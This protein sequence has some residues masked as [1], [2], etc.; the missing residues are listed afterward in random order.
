MKIPLRLTPSC[1]SSI[2]RCILNGES[3]KLPPHF[4]CNHHIKLEVLLPLEALSQIQ[5]LKEESTT[6]PILSHFNPSLPTIVETDAADYAFSFDSCQLL[7]A[8]T[9]ENLFSSVGDQLHVAPRQ[10]QSSHVSHENVTQ[11]PNPFQH[12]L[13]FSGNFTS[14]ASASPPNPPRRFAY[15]RAQPPPPDETLTLFPP[16]LALTTPYAFTHPPLPSL[17]SH[18]ALPPCLLHC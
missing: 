18:G 17:R 8:D 9:G 16:I 4:S 3:R 10:R 14:L 15:L 11:S 5:I 13:Q 6:S 2:F 1:L 12:Y 7:P